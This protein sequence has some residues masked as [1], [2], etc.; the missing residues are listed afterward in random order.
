MKT[1]A[2]FFWLFSPRTWEQFFSWINANNDRLFIRIELSS[3]T[4]SIFVIPS[5]R[6]D[7]RIVMRKSSERRN[8]IFSRF[9]ARAWNET[10]RERSKVRNGTSCERLFLL[11]FGAH[12]EVQL[13]TNIICEIVFN[14]N[15][16]LWM[17][18]WNYGVAWIRVWWWPIHEY[19]PPSYMLQYFGV[20][21]SSSGN[22]SPSFV[23]KGI[24]G[25]LNRHRSQ[26]W[27]VSLLSKSRE[28]KQEG[29]WEEERTR[30][31]FT[32]QTEYLYS[33]FQLKIGTIHHHPIIQVVLFKT[34]G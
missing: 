14:A 11:Y 18:A 28:R 21:C 34:Q 22:W 27:A 3:V 15:E 13:R 7:G 1:L 24:L 25:Y 2:Y 10:T 8:R 16:W 12:W 5:Y 17:L 32:S 31:T 29:G 33:S 4:V 9:C 23:T 6:M 26:F 20:N 30:K 19:F